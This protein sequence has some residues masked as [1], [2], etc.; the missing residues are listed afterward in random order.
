MG[1]EETMVVD[2]DPLKT[3]V[4]GFDPLLLLDEETFP[5]LAL[6]VAGVAEKK[7]ILE[8]L[9]RCSRHVETRMVGRFQRTM[10]VRTRNL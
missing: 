7:V 9:A 5:T 4:V 8:R 2:L 3:M 6:V 10:R 1:E